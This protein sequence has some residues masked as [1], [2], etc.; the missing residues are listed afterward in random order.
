MLPFAPLGM[1]KGG[2]L[3]LREPRRLHGFTTRIIGVG[4]I[5]A[6]DDIPGDFPIIAQAREALRRATRHDTPVLFTGGERA[7]RHDFA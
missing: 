4:T 6:F 2:V 7:E 5:C 3:V 1:G